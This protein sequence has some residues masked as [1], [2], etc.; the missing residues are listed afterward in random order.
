MK[1]LL[2]VMLIL[3][4]VFLTILLIGRLFGLL[5]VENIRA[6][7]VYAQSIDPLWVFLAVI[8]LLFLDI[9][10]TIPTLTTTIL[11]GFFLGFPLGA[12][13]AFLG[14]MAAILTGYGLSCLWGDKGV[15]L[16]VRDPQEREEMATTFLKT[17]PLMIVFSRSVPMLPEIS[18][19]MAGVTKMNFWHYAVFGVLSTAP[20]ALIGAYAGSVSS[21]ESPQ[22]AI[23]AALFLYA[24]LGLGWWVFRRLL[25]N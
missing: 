22:P 12:L 23:F 10:V 16:I 11:A 5:T 1:P 14:M 20:F 4:V 2:K 3:G 25:K 21:I 7:L 18:A 6:L 19:C 17:G 13:A 9:F 15:A 8:V 24:V